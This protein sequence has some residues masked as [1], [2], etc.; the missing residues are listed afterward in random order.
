[1]KTGTASEKVS[2]FVLIVEGSG[3]HKTQF[4]SFNQQEKLYRNVTE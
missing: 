3:L 1:M 4:S 2:D